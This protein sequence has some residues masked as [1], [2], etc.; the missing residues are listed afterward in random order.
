MPE[1][2]AAVPTTAQGRKKYDEKIRQKKRLRLSD[3][4]VEIVNCTF[5]AVEI[6]HFSKTQRLNTEKSLWFC[7]I[8]FTNISPFPSVL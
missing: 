5:G 4:H 7:F 8:C 2:I 6:Y 3:V 1:R